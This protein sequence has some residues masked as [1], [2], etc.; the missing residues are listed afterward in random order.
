M[1]DKLFVMMGRAM[2]GADPLPP[3]PETT[4]AD[5]LD[6]TTRERAEV[7]IAMRMMSFYG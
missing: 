1:I 2:M 4:A 6:R 7:E 3:Q 5:V